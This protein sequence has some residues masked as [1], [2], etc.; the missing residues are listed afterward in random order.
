MQ[1]GFGLPAGLSVLIVGANAIKKSSGTYHSFSSLSSFAEKNQT[2]ETP[3]VLAI[4]LL[5][6]VCCDMLKK[7]IKA[8]RKETDEKA[9]MLYNFAENNS[10]FKLFVKV[11]KFRSSTTIVFEVFDK[12]SDKIVSKLQ[13]YGL[14]VGK[15]YGEFKEK[16]I[17]IANFP[18][19]SM[20]DIKQLIK[21]LIL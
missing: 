14:I 19:H 9:E 11:E 8:I 13:R 2:P 10:I 6:K 16:H 15:G 1:K 21:G 5:G 12:T 4:Y 20:K 18:S 7:G 3:N 17:R